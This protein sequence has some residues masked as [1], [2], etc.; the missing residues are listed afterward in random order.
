MNPGWSPDGRELFY[1]N[2]A[3]LIVVPVE[4]DPMFEQGTAETVFEEPPCGVAELR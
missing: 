4:T 3:A 1:T 2:G